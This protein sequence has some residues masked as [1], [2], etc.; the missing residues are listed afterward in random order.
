MGLNDQNPSNKFTHSWILYLSSKEIS[1]Q[2]HREIDK[3][4]S[5]Y[6]FYP[7]ADW[8]RYGH[9]APENYTVLGA[10]RQPKN[11][12]VVFLLDNPYS[13]S[14]KQELQLIIYCISESRDEIEELN[15]SIEELKQMFSLTDRKKH[16]DR[17]LTERL[18]RVHGKKS[19]AGITAI[20]SIYSLIINAFSLYLRKLPIPD[21]G[22]NLLVAGYKTL[23]VAIHYSALL[24]L[25]SVIIIVGLFLLKY[26]FLL[27]K[28]L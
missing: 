25:L 9:Q 6:S 11:E 13:S 24:L 14:Q 18:G 15:R 19:L 3:I 4:F 1:T 23:I 8:L 16:S 26:G 27:I 22:N 7:Q 17:S 2:I 5:S 10:W 20:I 28:R 12:M 21:M